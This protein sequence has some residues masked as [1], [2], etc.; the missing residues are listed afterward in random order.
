MP[1]AELATRGR[2]ADGRFGLMM[3]LDRQYN[4]NEKERNEMVDG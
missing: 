2:K 1:K 4:K 3:S